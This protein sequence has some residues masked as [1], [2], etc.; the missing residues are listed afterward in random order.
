MRVATLP[1]ILIFLANFA[2]GQ[3]VYRCESERGVSYSDAP[4]INAKVIDAIPTKGAHSL[5]GQKTS[6][7]Q[8][9]HEE[10]REIFD[11]A[12][13][14]LT[15]MTHEQMNVMRKRQKLSPEERNECRK[16]DTLINREDEDALFLYKA[17]RRYFDLRC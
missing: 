1:F 17:R 15:E 7:T 6:N 9:R 12:F 3:Q 13:K 10:V 4:C 14:P 2:L 11:N 5:S 8:S 16:L